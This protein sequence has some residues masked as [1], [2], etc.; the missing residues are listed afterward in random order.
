MKD[1]YGL[2]RYVS[3]KVRSSTGQINE[4]HHYGLWSDILTDHMLF[5]LMYSRAYYLDASIGM[6]DKDTWATAY[7]GT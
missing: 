2:I 6:R 4:F 5:N 7:L 3:R 1:M